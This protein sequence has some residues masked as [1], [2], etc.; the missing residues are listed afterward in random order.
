MRLP[1][2]PNRIVYMDLGSGTP[3]PFAAV[4]HCRRSLR[5]DRT[6]R[7]RSGIDV[8]DPYVWSSRA[9]QEVFVDLSD[10]GL[11]SMYPASRWSACAPGHHGYQ[12]ACELIS[13]Q[14]STG[15]NGSPVFANP[16]KTDPPS[17]LFLSQ[18]SAG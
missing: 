15:P 1:G 14:A 3:R 9:L 6:C 2:G 18:T 10:V 17:L 13:G 7:G 5:L 4:K 8:N 16:G 11:A 12:R